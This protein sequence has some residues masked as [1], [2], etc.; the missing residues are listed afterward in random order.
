M[1]NI[2]FYIFAC[3]NAHRHSQQRSYLLVLLFKWKN[4]QRTW[5]NIAKI[6]KMFV[7]THNKKKQIKT[8]MIP[9]FKHQ[10]S[11]ILQSER[12][13]SDIHVNRAL[14]SGILKKLPMY[15]FKLTQND[16]VQSFYSSNRLKIDQ[17]CIWSNWWN[18]VFY[19]RKIVCGCLNVPMHQN[20]K[21]SHSEL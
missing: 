12:P 20:Y 15:M 10:N 7:L 6:W 4:G 8:V 16:L 9:Y 3:R 19:T 2:L 18:I 21:S 17:G 5:T 1:L 14:W 11:I 13:L